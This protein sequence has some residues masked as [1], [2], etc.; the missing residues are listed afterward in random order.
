MKRFLFASDPSQ[1]SLSRIPLTASRLDTKQ[2]SLLLQAGCA[3]K[4]PIEVGVMTAETMFKRW[5]PDRHL[6][7][8]ESCQ[9]HTRPLSH[10]C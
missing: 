2:N 8:D 6:W 4:T 7:T 5:N 9:V 1:K 3:D 10:H